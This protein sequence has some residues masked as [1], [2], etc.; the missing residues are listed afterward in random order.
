MS[1]STGLFVPKHVE[2]RNEIRYSYNPNVAPGFQQS[3]WFWNTTVA[4]SFLKDKAT[5]TLKVYDVLNQNTNARRT[6]NANFIQDV[7]STVLEQYFLLSFSWK[8]NTLGNKGE[9]GDGG[10]FFF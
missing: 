1:L 2:W 8:F 10:V 5:V 6:A 9:T 3:A 7:Q 4:Y